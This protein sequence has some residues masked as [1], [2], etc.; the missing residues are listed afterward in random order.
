MIAH[1]RSTV[2]ACNRRSERHRTLVREKCRSKN[3]RD[4]GKARP[5]TS[6]SLIRIREGIGMPLAKACPASHEVRMEGSP[7][8]GQK[9]DDLAAL[10]VTLHN[11]PT[12]PECQ[13]RLLGAIA[14]QLQHGQALVILRNSETGE[15]I[16]RAH[17]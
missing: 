5:S 14:A 17:V 15:Q 9:L 11:A 3:G 12:V 10:L 13:T 8:R 4:S 2:L 16:G 1:V 6:I 7:A